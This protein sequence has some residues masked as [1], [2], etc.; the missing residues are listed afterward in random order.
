[1]ID[2]EVDELVARLRRPLF[3]YN[4]NIHV[5]K[6]KKALDKARKEIDQ[7]VREYVFKPVG[8]DTC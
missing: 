7:I 3:V 2:K 6:K 1:M 5:P 4:M 8:Q